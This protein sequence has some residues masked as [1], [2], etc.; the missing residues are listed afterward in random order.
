MDAKSR[1][2]AVTA[3]FSV[4]LIAFFSGRNVEERAMAAKA[5]AN[6]RVLAP[7]PAT[8]TPAPPSHRQ[9]EVTEIVALP[10]A[11]FYE[12]LRGAPGEAREKWASE[13][14]AMP[15]GP[16]RRAAVSG[17]Y[18]LLVQFDPEAA[19]KAIGEIE[20]VP[21]QRLALDA[22]VNAAPGFAL[23]LMAELSLT[24]QDRITGKRDHLSDVLLEWALIDPPA[25]AQFINDH[26]EA[27]DEFGRGRYLYVDQV[28]STWAA[29]D[30]TAAKEWIDRKER[31]VGWEIREFFIGGWYE[32]DRA[33]AVSY[34]LTHAEEPEMD[35]AIG[36]ILQNLYSDSKEESA[37][38]IENLPESK[39]STAFT[40][41]FR[42]LI[43]SEEEDSGDLLFTPHA[44][45]SWMV[46]FPPAYWKGALGGLFG[47]DAKGAADLL[48][49]IQQSPPDVREAAAAEYSAPFDQ[50]APEKLAPVLQVADSVLRD[51]L[52]R[53][54]IKNQ[55]LDFD[56]ATIA[57]SNAALSPEQK[58]HF[59]QIIAAVKAEKKENYGSE[60]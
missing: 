55:S 33:A 56:E 45:A 13:L 52:F 8:S 53:A 23:P 49:W 27:I 43:L 1:W 20:D 6:A 39:R 54:M 51:Q 10:F 19:V 37:K 48:A 22:A 25:A 44:I 41:A 58:R 5:R 9:L 34:T 42:H 11:K 7:S 50:P 35:A 30:P 2:L 28:I 32:N 57:V 26:T 59:F 15:E 16:R 3:L 40:E 60:K 47:N 46:E 21:L 31:W 4:A 29:V 18:K 17:F 14:M 36:R 38:F 12:A 24:L